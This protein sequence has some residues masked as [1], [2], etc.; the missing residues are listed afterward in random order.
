MQGEIELLA[1]YTSNIFID[2][3]S[4]GGPVVCSRDEM[5]P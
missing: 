1:D 2:L 4:Q 5:L 3:L